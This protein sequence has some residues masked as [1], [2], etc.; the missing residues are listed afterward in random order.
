V[1]WSEFGGTI[2]TVITVSGESHR[3]MPSWTNSN[4]MKRLY[5]FVKLLGGAKSIHV[6]KGSWLRLEFLGAPIPT[7]TALLILCLGRHGALYDYDQ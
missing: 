6:D 4:R 7:T 5:F 3:E 1:H 2:A